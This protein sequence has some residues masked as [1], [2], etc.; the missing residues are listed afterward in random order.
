MRDDKTPNWVRIFLKEPPKSALYVSKTNSRSWNFVVFFLNFSDIEN[1]QSLVIISSNLSVDDLSMW[2]I[3]IDKTVISY[4]NT[5][6]L[7]AGYKYGL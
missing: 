6:I 4:Q 2:D 5:N 3:A 7:M 1:E